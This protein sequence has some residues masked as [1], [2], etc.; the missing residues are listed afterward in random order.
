M[1]TTEFNCEVTFTQEGPFWHAYTKGKNSSIIFKTKEDY[2]YAINALCAVAFMFPKVRIVALEIMDTHVHIM[3][4]GP[5]E[6]VEE[7]C[8]QYE[9]KMRRAFAIRSIKDPT[10][11]PLPRHFR[12]EFRKI[13]TLADARYVIVYINRNAFV[14]CRKYTPFNYPWGSGRYYFTDVPL[15]QKLSDLDCREVKQMFRSRMPD[16][17]D[18]LY[19]V[20]GHVALSCFCY[21]KLGM[22]LYRDAHQYFALCYKNV[23]AYSKIAVDIDDSEFLSDAELFDIVSAKVRSMYNVAKIS[24]LTSAQRLDIAKS[25]HYEYKSSNGQIRRILGISQ[26]EVDSL[27]PLSAKKS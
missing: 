4:A 22:S 5:K 3:L 16:L 23:E 17:P 10:Q 13:E 24:S 2:D 14:A 21:I 12:F 27:F 26:F 8:S 20:D 1:N 25:L 6:L 19:V 18:D 9:R 11:D 7:M 15:T